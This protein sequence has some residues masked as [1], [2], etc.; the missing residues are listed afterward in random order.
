LE[1][2]APFDRQ[3]LAASVDRWAE[4]RMTAIARDTVKMLYLEDARWM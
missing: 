3:L 1:S 4:E 2:G